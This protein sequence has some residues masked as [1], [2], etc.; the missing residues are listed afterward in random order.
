MLKQGSRMVHLWTRENAGFPP[1]AAASAA[2]RYS[3]RWSPLRHPMLAW[4]NPV[5]LP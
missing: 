5:G 1:Q 3:R 4:L 2:I